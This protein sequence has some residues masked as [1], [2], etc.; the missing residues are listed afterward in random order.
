MA[1]ELLDRLAIPVV[2]RRFRGMSVDDS[3]SL[4]SD[5]YVRACKISFVDLP[6]FLFGVF[7]GVCGENSCNVFLLLF[8]YFGF[9]SSGRFA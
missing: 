1:V 5:G 7:G 2:V 8:T 3:R 9:L 6:L 4:R